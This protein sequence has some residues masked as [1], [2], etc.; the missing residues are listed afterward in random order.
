MARWLLRRLGQALATLVVA[1][2]ILFFLVRL[3]PG[4]P[5]AAIVGERPVTQEELRSLKERYGLDRSIPGQFATFVG[6]LARLDL[7][8]SIQYRGIPVTTLIRQRLPASL[9]LGGTVLLIN[10][11]I[12]IALGAWQAVRKDGWPD[13]VL[14]TVS[15]AAYSIPSFWL[16]MVLAWLVA[17]K[18][19]FLPAAGTLDPLIP[20]DA[21]WLT[22][23]ADVGRHLILPALTLSVV[24]IGA[25]MRFQR[26]AMI[27]VLRLDY[28]RTARAKGVPEGQV[29]RRHA[30]RNALFPVI[31]LFGLWLPLL[32]T[33][34]VFVE[35]V[36]HWTGLGLL[37]ADAVASRDYPV[38]VG[39]GM[40]VATLVVLGNL[41]TD[42][43]YMA[44]DP[45]V[46]AA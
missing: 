37:A 18:W 4:D 14:G 1:T 27:E 8:R 30:W 39:T 22:R 23:A 10:F 15:L 21:P 33:G 11:T 32:A 46:R 2:T 24:T 13:R 36:F 31:T 42:L 9:L 43:V 25:A 44:L 3:V 26:N 29:L 35:S 12:G 19:G 28:V 38:L 7:G 40:L 17:I 45:R 5:V 34:A 41:V 20:P 16:G 6:D